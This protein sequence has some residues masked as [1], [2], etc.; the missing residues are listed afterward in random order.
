[1]GRSNKTGGS[2]GYAFIEFKFHEVAKTA[3]ETMNNY[4]FFDKLLKCELVPEEKVRPTMFRGK[5]N[6]KQPPAR[7]ARAIAKQQ[8]NKQRDERQEQKRRR[9]QLQ[10]LKKTAAKLQSM[11]VEYSVDLPTI[12]K[13]ILER[14][15]RL[16]GKFKTSGSLLAYLKYYCLPS[17]D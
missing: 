13:E 15:A 3:A 1:M 11:G 2:R 7:K 14:K 5:I 4:L 16:K 12:E 10:A 8:V 6:P 17:D 9:K